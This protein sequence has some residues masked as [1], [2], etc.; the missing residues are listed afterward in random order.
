LGHLS[1]EK[2]AFFYILKYMTKDAESLSA[3]LPVLR[4]MY[5]RAAQYPSIAEDSG[6]DIR[7]TMFLVTK[8]LNHR[9]GAAEVSLQMAALGLLGYPSNIFSHETTYVFIRPAIASVRRT[10]NP[11]EEAQAQ[12]EEQEAEEAATTNPVEVNRTGESNEP[13]EGG[14]IHFDR[15]PDIGVFDGAADF[16]RDE[17]RQIVRNPAGEV[18][19]ISQH[20]HYMY[21]GLA[22]K[23]FTLY[24][25]CGTVMV[26]KNSAAPPTTAA[27]GRQRNAAFEFDPRH[28]QVET[29]NLTLR[30]KHTV[31][32]LAGS[33]PPTWPGINDGTDR[34]LKAADRWAEYVLVLHSPW[35]LET[36]RPPQELT[37]SALCVWYQELKASPYLDDRVTAFWVENLA[38]GMKLDN[39]TMSLMSQWRYRY[40]KVWTSEDNMLHT[41]VEKVADDDEGSNLADAL[42]QSEYHV[43]LALQPETTESNAVL[44]ARETAQ[45]LQSLSAGSERSG[46]AQNFSFVES[47]PN[48]ITSTFESIC[49][50]MSEFDEEQDVNDEEAATSVTDAPQAQD[51]PQNEMD[52]EAIA[53]SL[54]TNAPPVSNPVIDD[55]P[56]ITLTEAQNAVLV[57]VC[58]WYNRRCNPQNDERTVGVCRKFVTGAAGTG[59]SHLVKKIVS[60][61]GASRVKCVSFQGIAAH[62]LPGGRTIH[63]AFCIPPIK[64]S[65]GHSKSTAR[66]VEAR[67]E[68]REA[69]LLVVDEISTT[70]ADLL[71][72]MDHR[73]RLWLN[74]PA[75]FGGL[76][77]LLI[78]D[79]FQ[80]PPVGGLS[81]MKA[82]ADP[83]SVA[84]NLLKSFERVSLTVQKRADQD[85]KKHIAQLDIMR[86]PGAGMNAIKSSGM[87][88][89]VKVLSRYDFET[90]DA[91]Y[92]ATVIVSEN[93]T[94]MTTNKSQAFAF[95]KR[96]N[97]PVISWRQT[98][99]PNTLK[100]FNRAS[101]GSSQ[102]LETILDRF[103]EL[104]FYFVAGAPV[105]LKDNIST[106]NGLANGRIC[107]LHSLTLE[108][109]DVHLWPEIGQVPAGAE[110]RLPRPPLSVN[111][112]L[113]ESTE[114]LRR[115]SLVDGQTVIP[116][117][118][119]PKNARS[120]SLAKSTANKFKAD[121]NKAKLEY[122]DHGLDLAF[123]VTYHKVQG[124]TLKRVIVD[125]NVPSSVSVAAFYVA[126][127]RVTRQTNIRF[128]PIFNRH[129]TMLTLEAKTF[130]D[131]LVEW[132]KVE[133]P[134]PATVAV[135]S[136]PKEAAAR[137]AHAVEQDGSE[138][139]EDRSQA[140]RAKK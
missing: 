22:F 129:K 126:V 74:N 16:E 88:N 15:D 31:P 73:L 110:Y 24:Q 79:M 66:F 123:A 83:T 34:W 106:A 96:N 98:L 76:G 92:D 1:Q 55:G 39:K 115:H 64:K 32:S 3:V 80:L 118:Q 85:D 72:K 28:S 37:Y 48:E 44:Q 12:T 127:S 26:T 56:D 70:T 100:H 112:R 125:L 119:R 5:Q 107:T 134:K 6:S 45:A 47:Q 19:L 75:P 65:G 13:N 81:I 49:N 10:L 58:K 136:R 132:W 121:V 14:D 116:M 23:L 9:T 84:G 108:P 101:N 140:K 111:I 135:V 25:F 133:R 105:V 67:E 43:Q 11:D 139:E 2:A 102:T 60:R 54:A 57:D 91:W 109:M 7:D 89:T 120:I 128:L 94:R 95:A 63:S 41:G 122:I 77:V 51:D 62:L 38:H 97:V 46:C 82:A 93:V 117:K 18:I 59:K 124:R 90:D 78:G 35:D 29:H 8:M 137:K 27:G 4:D 36:R 87:L 42:L 33:A 113:E 68:F 50:G 69:A 71:E 20:E 114:F 53:D 21:R 103:A 138:E 40:A 99:H 30:S 130:D 61:L 52:E 104:T 131:Y 17:S 86:D